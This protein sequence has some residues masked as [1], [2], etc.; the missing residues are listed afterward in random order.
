MAEAGYDMNKERGKRKKLTEKELKEMR[1][2][3]YEEEYGIT[4]EDKLDRIIR[5]LSAIIYLIGQVYARGYK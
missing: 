4:I 5:K 2:K 1:K 3:E